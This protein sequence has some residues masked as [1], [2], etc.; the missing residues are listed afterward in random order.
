MIVPVLLTLVTAVAVAAT[1]T[2]LPKPPPD[3]PPPPNGGSG[4]L[5]PGTRVRVNVQ[6]WIGSLRA[7]PVSL[8]VVPMNVT[9]VLVEVVQPQPASA[10][11]SGNI[12]G[13]WNEAGALVM[14]PVPAFVPAVPLGAVESIEIGGPSPAPPLPLNAGP[15]AAPPPDL[16]IV[17]RPDA[18]TMRLAPS[19]AYRGRLDLPPG[20]RLDLERL[21]ARLLAQ[22]GLA[23][24]TIRVLSSPGEAAPHVPPFALANP[25]QGTRWFHARYLGRDPIDVPRPRELVVM[26]QVRGPL[27]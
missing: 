13:Y 19:R 25:G 16:P 7:P 14:L 20:S 22:A 8:A 3:L 6:E 15:I 23:P 2:K 24:E 11:F 5:S 21:A 9:H 12:V 17:A 1:R 18:P 4:R 10:S 27:M 26:W